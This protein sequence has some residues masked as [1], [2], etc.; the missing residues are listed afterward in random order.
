MLSAVNAL[1][2][3]AAAAVAVLTVAA[4]L[5][6]SCSG[7]AIPDCAIPSPSETAADGGPDPCHCD[8]P[9]SLNVG[10]CPCLSGTPGQVDIY[11]SCIATYWV[12]VMDAGAD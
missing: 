12:E 1:R 6:F 10:A 8:P 5:G 9:P 11:R 2:L 7:P 3:P 4:T